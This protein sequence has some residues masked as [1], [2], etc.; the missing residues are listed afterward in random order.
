MGGNIG[1]GNRL[2]E[3]LLLKTSSFS[4][5]RMCVWVES[6]LG[7][8]VYSAWVHC[9]IDDV[10]RIKLK[11]QT[12]VGSD[13]INASAVNVSQMVLR[14]CNIPAILHVQGYERYCTYFVT[15]VPLKHTI[16]DFW[17]MIAEYDSR[18]IVLCDKDTGQVS[19]EVHEGSI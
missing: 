3:S 15:Q 1:W 8:F 13:Y 6:G 17:R 16:S 14:C 9:L 18:A 19:C 4:Y 5:L 10:C 11:S 2:L 12:D 7:L